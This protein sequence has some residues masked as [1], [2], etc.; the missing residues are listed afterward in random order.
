MRYWTRFSH[1]VTLSDLAS[2]SCHT[3]FGEFCAE[4]RCAG[5][6]SSELWQFIIFN[7]RMLCQAKYD[8]R[9]DVGQT[10]FIILCGL[11]ERLKLEARHHYNCGAG[12]E[13]HIQ[14]HH[15]SVD[16]EQRQHANQRVSFEEVI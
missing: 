13:S 14:Y 2:K 9:N 1:P 12:V 10:N 6:Y 5:E 8:R 4:R 15:E 3:C 7:N 11:Q 16:V